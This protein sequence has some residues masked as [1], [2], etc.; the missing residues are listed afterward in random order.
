MKRTV[1]LLACWSIAG[2][3]P[4]FPDLVSRGVY[5]LEPTEVGRC[6]VVVTAEEKDGRLVVEGQLSRGRFPY[7][8]EA[9]TEVSIVAPN[10]SEIGRTRPVLRRSRNRR[11]SGTFAYFTAE[12]DRVPPPGTLIRVTPGRSPGA[13]I[14]GCESPGGEQPLD[15]RADE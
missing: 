5:R 2:C 10:G 6:R 3:G 14:P 8:L 12:F 11:S 13:H 4:L 9:E 15:K 7:P 1:R